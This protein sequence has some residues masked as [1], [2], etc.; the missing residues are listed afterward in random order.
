VNITGT[1]TA[2]AGAHRLEQIE[3][4]Q[5]GGVPV[6]NQHVDSERESD[7]DI[8]KPSLKGMHLAKPFDDLTDDETMPGIGLKHCDA[9]D[10]GTREPANGDFGT[11]IE[12][13]LKAQKKAS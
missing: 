3:P 2:D 9:H 7:F 8:D 4:G 13:S 10:N 12:T 6:E 1:R 5:T 11:Y